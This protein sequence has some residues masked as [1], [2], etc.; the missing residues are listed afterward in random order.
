MAKNLT[1]SGLWQDFGL[2]KDLRKIRVPEFHAV[3]ESLSIRWT[4]KKIH[5]NLLFFSIFSFF[6]N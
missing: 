1:N 6:Q 3:A 4:G 5:Q 2:E